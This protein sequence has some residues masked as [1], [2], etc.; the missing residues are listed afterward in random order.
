M[1]LYKITPTAALESRSTL[2]ADLDWLDSKLVDSRPYL[3]GDRFSR[4]D[5]TVAS[6]LA[7]FARPQEMPIYHELPVQALVADSERWRNRPVMHWVRT[8][9]RDNRL[10]SWSAAA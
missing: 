2:E 8:Q 1:R 9:Y 7:P 6:F 10:S 4:A 3:A 5:L